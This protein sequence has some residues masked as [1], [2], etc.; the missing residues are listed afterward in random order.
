M[1]DGGLSV[2]Q[3]VP[4][5]WAFLEDSSVLGVETVVRKVKDVFLSMAAATVITEAR[6]P[7]R[8]VAEVVWPEARHRS[9]LFRLCLVSVCSFLN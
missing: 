3:F 8:T 6:P 4:L 2:L 5:V 9:S 1:Y 7:L